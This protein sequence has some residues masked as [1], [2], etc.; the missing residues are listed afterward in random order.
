MAY[1]ELQPGE[2]ATSAVGTLMYVSPEVSCR[3]S[4]DSKVS[5]I[6]S[7]DISVNSVDEQ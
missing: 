3:K 1:R 5:L 7:T 4:Y 2:W 6:L